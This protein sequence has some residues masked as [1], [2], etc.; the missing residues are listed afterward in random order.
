M[1]N[2]SINQLHFK[3]N[4]FLNR[5]P[6]KRCPGGVIRWGKFPGGSCPGDNCPGVIVRVVVIR[7]ELS[8]GELSGA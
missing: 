6:M 3:I 2:C 7:G 8:W 1:N 4:T 5:E